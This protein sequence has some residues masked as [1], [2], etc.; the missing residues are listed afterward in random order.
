VPEDTKYVLIMVKDHTAWLY[1]DDISITEVPKPVATLANVKGEKQY[2]ATFYDGSRNWQLPQGG[3]AYTVENE[4]P[5]YVF[6]CIG[7]IIPAG[8]PVVIL[9]D[10]QAGDTENTKTIALSISG[11]RPTPRPYNIL[12]GSDLPV[13]V[14]QFGGKTVYVLGI[15]NNV[16]GFYPFSG[17]TIP[18]GKAYYL[19]E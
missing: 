13:D 15:K 12:S 18:A 4:S 2:V 17:N 10:K 8:T 3:L 1:V 19:A 11:T 14:S 16:L 7:D 6:F 5:E 9:L